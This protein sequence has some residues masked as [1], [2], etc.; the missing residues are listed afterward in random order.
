MTSD[1]DNSVL[2]TEV[3]TRRQNA[4]WHGVPAKILRGDA[5]WVE[6]LRVLEKRRVSPKH[7]PFFTFG[8]VARFVA[9]RDGR[10]VG[11]ISAQVNRR[12]L[13]AHKDAT[14]QFGFFDCSDDAAAANALVAAAADWLAARGLERMTGPFS[15]SI[16]EETGLLVDGFETPPAILMPH[17]ARWYDRLLTG[18]GC[19]K[20]I[21]V[22]AYRYD[23]SNPN[24]I[25]D[26]LAAIARRDPR[27]SVRPFDMKNYD[28]EVA[29]LIDIFNDAWSGNWGFVPFSDAE[30]AAFV[31]ETRHVLR[32]EWGQFVMV[33][34]EPV[35]FLFVLPD[36]NRVIQPFGGRLLPFNWVKLVAKFWSNDWKTARIPLLGLRR[37]YHSSPIAPGLLLLMVSEL[38][39]T[40]VRYQHDWIEFS[41][42]LETNRPMRR[43]AE[44]AAGPAQKTYRI[45]ERPTRL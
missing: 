9:Y 20:A 45:Y 39:A 28:R 15:L 26:R 1:R 3:V 4:D 21:D 29:L 38:L 16:N 23:F 36:I 30:I 24:P 40:S 14:G 42:V 35:G 7:S 6:P 5:A 25:V 43:I 37:S 13:E 8:E 12:H 32:D 31:A 34:G 2:V 19:R 27:L 44:M 33:D 11:R 22:L 18:A 17:G 41:W 10:P